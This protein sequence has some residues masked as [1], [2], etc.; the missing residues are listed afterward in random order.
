MK[1][2]VV[3]QAASGKSTIVEKLGAGLGDYSVFSVD[4]FIRQ[5]WFGL[6]NQTT[7]EMRASRTALW[8]LIGR[9]VGLGELRE[10]AFAQSEVR[11]F[12]EAETKPHVLQFVANV[13]K[14]MDVIVEYPHLGMMDDKQAV[15]EADL[16]VH[17]S[18]RE[19]VQL[20][21]LKERGWSNEKIS[22]VLRLQRANDI[23]SVIGVGEKVRTLDT[24]CYDV[25]R[26]VAILINDVRAQSKVPATARIG[27]FAGTFDP[28]TLGHLDMI[29][30]AAKCVD[31]LYVVC[32]SNPAKKT[33]FSEFEINE[34]VL[35]D[36]QSLPQQNII[37]LGLKDRKS[38]AGAASD[39]S[40]TILF[41]GI[42]G[43]ADLEYERALLDANRRISPHV[44]ICYLL[45]K[46]EFLTLSSSFVK[47][48]MSVEEWRVIVKPLVS[49][50]TLDQ[51]RMK[52]CYGPVDE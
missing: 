29:N 9:E 47:G 46:P 35:H 50:N 49:T 40:A 4:A 20:E 34:M 3:G 26:Q 21:R 19:H 8:V 42:R 45:P 39:L 14:N 32:A 33:L 16:I 36:V 27:A 30:E 38:V 44:T 5:Y 37:V 17:A 23:R 28:I 41:R 52:W 24:S 1:I 43:A 48:A 2:I 18:V 51:L 31:R 25:D 12:M 7:P 6:P 15:C 22:T 13:M 11:E 10:V